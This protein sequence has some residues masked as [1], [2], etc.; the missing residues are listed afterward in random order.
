MKRKNLRIKA[1]V[2]MILGLFPLAFT[3]SAEAQH[4]GKISKIGILRSGSPGDANI[5]GFRQGL[6]ELGYIEGQN[7]VMEYRWVD[8]DDRLLELAR[9]LVQKKVDV[10][11]TGSTPA[12]IAAKEATKTI[13]I[14]FGALSDPVGVGLVASLAR[15]G[16]NITGMSL[17]APEL[18]PKRLELLKETVP[19]LSRVAMLWNRS[20]PGMAARAKETQDAAH[21]MGVA[22]QDRGAK[23]S[24]ELENIF[25][26][27]TK[28]P[29]DGLLTMLDP[30]TT[31]HL[32]HIVDFTANH[33]LPGMYEERRF[34]QAG[35]LMSYGPNV[36]NLYRRA[37][38]YVDKILKGSK[39]ADL[40]VEQPMKF[41]LF[42]NLHTAK[43]LGLAIP[44]SV[45]FRADDV[46]K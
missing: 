26:V 34:V 3:H 16:G 18:W 36:V 15:P 29:P 4:P 5:E 45:L 23:D 6:R 39:P 20:N 11:L 30:F 41:E 13:P 40:P 17:L 25:N 1:I 35:G 33:H 43:A 42:I 2:L 24:Q 8:R 38:T 28:D 7:V 44:D 12:T 22:V 21:H 37:A 14:V 31:L 10:I 46:I 19:K 9:E 27:I 32:K